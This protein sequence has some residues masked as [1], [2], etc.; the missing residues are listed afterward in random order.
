MYPNAA[1]ILKTYSETWD[2]YQK[3]THLRFFAQNTGLDAGLAI[4]R[5][6]NTE[7]KEPSFSKEQLIS[8]VLL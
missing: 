8:V 4:I 7:I 3:F 1:Y 5:E 2:T 6:R